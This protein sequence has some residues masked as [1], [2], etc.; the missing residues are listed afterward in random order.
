MGTDILM[1]P[2][3]MKKQRIQNKKNG[4]F[5]EALDQ[6]P[7][8]PLQNPQNLPRKERIKNLLYRLSH[9]GAIQSLGYQ[10]LAL[11]KCMY[12]LKII[13]FFEFLFQPDFQMCVM[14][15]VG[16]ATNNQLTGYLIGIKV[17]K[18][19]LN[20]YNWLIGA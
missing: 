18:Q 14:L 4:A 3:P 1:T 6:V 19:L 15:K 2:I 16:M 12:L 13:F 17:R 11:S 5:L 8:P 7:L 10:F 20:F 9:I